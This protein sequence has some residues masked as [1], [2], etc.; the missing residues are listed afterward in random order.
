MI[1]DLARVGRPHARQ[2]LRD[3]ECRHG[4]PRI[5]GPAQDREQIL[6]VARFQE[7]R[8]AVLDERNLPL[9]ELDLKGS[10]AG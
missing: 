9:A 8:A 10:R 4:V 6:Y 5:V 3:T 2:K 7:F 1:D